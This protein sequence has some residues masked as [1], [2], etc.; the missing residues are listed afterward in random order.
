MPY[1]AAK[2]SLQ[3]AYPTLLTLPGEGKQPVKVID[4]ILPA[5]LAYPLPASLD[6]R[7]QL[8]YPRSL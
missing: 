4:E 3:L 7:S 8:A 1:K 6:F 5:R 2:D